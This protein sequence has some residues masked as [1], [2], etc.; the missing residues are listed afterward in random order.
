MLSFLRRPTGVPPGLEAPE[1]PNPFTQ[2]TAP[3][4]TPPTFVMT[5]RREPHEG[6]SFITAPDSQRNELYDLNIAWQEAPDPIRASPF[7]D[8]GNKVHP[9]AQM[10]IQSNLAIG[11]DE[12]IDEQTFH[13]GKL[14]GYIH[15]PMYAGA[16]QPSVIRANIAE[17]FPTTYGSQYAVEGVVPSGPVLA[18]GFSYLPE[19]SQDGYPY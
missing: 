12:S 11:Y 17:A 6:P 14:L 8:H 16:Q 5:E 3:P 13:I 10:A 4:G 9:D 1:E 7:Y 15:R 19:S 18:S 2:A